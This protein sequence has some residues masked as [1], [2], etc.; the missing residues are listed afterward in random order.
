MGTKATKVSTPKSTLQKPTQFL[1]SCGYQGPTTGFPATGPVFLAGSTG[2]V[3]VFLWRMF[4]VYSACRH[5]FLR[6]Y[7]RPRIPVPI[8]PK[9]PRDVLY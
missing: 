6:V 2:T 4:T 1:C 7:L 3:L 5:I 9:R 8:L